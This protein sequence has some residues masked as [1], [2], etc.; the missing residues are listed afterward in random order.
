MIL[1]ASTLSAAVLLAVGVGAG[2]VTPALAET[3]YSGGEPECGVECSTDTAPNT[4]TI[5]LDHVVRPAGEAAFEAS[6][7]ELEELGEQFFKDSSLSS[8]GLACV[9][10]HAGMSFYNKTFREAYPHRVAMPYKRAGLETV[11][12]ESMVQF[13]MIM[14]MAAAPL[15]WQSKELAALAAYVE[16]VQVAY[17]AASR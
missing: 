15:P 7:D 1:K 8:N 11:D 16:K 12:A 6:H 2:V 3:S 17:A 10:C 14:P 5:P 13:C 9:S 4:S